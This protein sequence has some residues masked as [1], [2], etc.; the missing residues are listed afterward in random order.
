[1]ANPPFSAVS[2]VVPEV[3]AKYKNACLFFQNENFLDFGM[4]HHTKQK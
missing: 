3:K 4:N 2:A 1:M